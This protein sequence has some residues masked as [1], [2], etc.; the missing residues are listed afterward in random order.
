MQDFEVLAVFVDAKEHAVIGRAAQGR[1]AV[2]ESIV[3]FD[4]RAGGIAAVQ[5][6]A[7]LVGRKGEQKRVLASRRDLEQSAAL[8]VRGALGSNLGCTIEIAIGS[9]DQNIGIVT[10]RADRDLLSRTGKTE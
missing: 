6:V 3:G 2:E 4:Q 10:E 5:I 1:G 7:I 8:G 9:L